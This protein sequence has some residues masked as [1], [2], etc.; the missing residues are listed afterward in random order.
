MRLEIVTKAP[1][2]NISLTELSIGW[3]P[4]LL[5]NVIKNEGNAVLS[6]YIHQLIGDHLSVELVFA[7]TAN[8]DR[9]IVANR[10]WDVVFCVALEPLALAK[11]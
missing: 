11:P 4:H 6:R 10:I 7:R 5:A 1:H 8:T 2:E 9:A 3:L